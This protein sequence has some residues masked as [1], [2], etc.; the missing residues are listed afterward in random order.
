MISIKNKEIY[1]HSLKKL[2]FILKTFKGHENI[3]ITKTSREN[4]GAFKN[5]EDFSKDKLG[6]FDKAAEDLRLASRS[7]INRV[8]M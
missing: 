2:N 3:L 4:L 6:D 7:L 5:L 8:W 1:N